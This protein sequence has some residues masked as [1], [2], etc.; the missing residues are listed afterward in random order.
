MANPDTAA[1]HMLSAS[2]DMVDML[3]GQPMSAVSDMLRACL[4]ASEGRRLIAADYGSIEGRGGA[5]LAGET[6]KIEAFNAHDRGEGPGIYEL[7][8]ADILSKRVDDI[9]KHERQ[10][11]G[12]VPELGLLFQGGVMAFHSMARIYGVDMAQAY[13]PL[14]RVADGELV[15]SASGIEDQIHDVTDLEARTAYDARVRVV[16][17]EWS[18]YLRF[19]TEALDLRTG[20]GSATA[21]ATVSADSA[22][23]RSGDGS[24]DAVAS[25]SAA[26][27]TLPVDFRAGRGVVLVHAASVVGWRA[28]RFGIGQAEAHAASEAAS[29][30]ARS[31]DGAAIALTQS[32]AALQRIVPI[33]GRLIGVRHHDMDAVEIDEKEGTFSVAHDDADSVSA[34]H[35]ETTSVKPKTK[36]SQE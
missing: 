17:G 33:I 19:E 35:H 29:A 23:S 21:V 25:A 24:A 5:W 4:T 3:Y 6:W 18:P 12:K 14:R 30:A 11:Y 27:S 31:G 2:A 13:E 36:E 22:A 15:H 1:K 34:S 26:G 7:T 20:E 16:G 10:G 32:L 28:S 9:T 8:A